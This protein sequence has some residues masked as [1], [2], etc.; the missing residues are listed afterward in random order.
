MRV[1]RHFFGFHPTLL[2]SFGRGV[3]VGLRDSV[4]KKILTQLMIKGALGCTTLMRLAPTAN[5]RNPRNLVG[6]SGK[7][8]TFTKTVT[9]TRNVTA[10]D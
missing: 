4:A 3:V 5:L 10:T 6:S 8:G 9:N 1:R 2:T 7:T